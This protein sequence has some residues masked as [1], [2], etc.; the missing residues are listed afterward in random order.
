MSEKTPL[1]Y[2]IGGLPRTGKTTVAERFAHDIRAGSIET[3][4]IRILFNPTPTSK[5]RVGSSA[6]IAVV[7]KKMRPRLECLLE[8]L[9]TNKTEFVLNGECID[10]NMIAESPN[11]NQ[12]ASCFMGLNNPDLAFERIREVADPKDWAM[13]KSDEELRHILAKYAMRS[14][15]LGAACLRLNL[16]YVDASSDFIAAHEY[17]YSVL[18]AARDII[19]F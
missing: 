9:I 16:P 5:I 13:T 10:P 1:V 8:S 3:D 14:Q 19:D 11:S 15:A 2:V 7:T 12:I 17:V 4:H 18:L 6:D